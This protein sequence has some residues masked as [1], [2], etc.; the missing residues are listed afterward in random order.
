MLLLYSWPR[1]LAWCFPSKPN[2]GT[3]GAHCSEEVED[4]KTRWATEKPA[5]GE[6]SEDR[7][8]HLQNAHKPDH[9][10]PSIVA[11][12]A[13]GR[14]LSICCTVWWRNQRRGSLWWTSSRWSSVSAYA[15]AYSASRWC[16]TAVEWVLLEHA[17][18]LHSFCLWRDWSFSA[19]YQLAQAGV[20][21]TFQALSGEGLEGWW[22]PSAC[23]HPHLM[24]IPLQSPRLPCSLIVLV[25][26]SRFLCLGP[27]WTSSLPQHFLR[28]FQRPTLWSLHVLLGTPIL[29]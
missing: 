12:A 6:G 15:E 22:S 5:V 26:Y 27:V 3:T 1:L 23:R 14:C 10:L 24:T 25:P 4:H 11:R 13:S 7:I 17:G 21:W 16:A 29:P 2:V 8:A 9:K 19:V 20:P 28:V 18:L